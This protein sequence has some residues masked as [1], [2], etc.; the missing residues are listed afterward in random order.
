MYTIIIT[1]CVLLSSISHVSADFTSERKKVSI[2]CNYTL[3]TCVDKLQKKEPSNDAEWCSLLGASK[4]NFTAYQ[5][6]AKIGLCTEEEFADL[7]NGACGKKDKPQQKSSDL[8]KNAF[9]AIKSANK[10]C[11]DTIVTC[12]FGSAIATIL[13]QEE[14][15][16][17]MF[18]VGEDCLGSDCK[19]SYDTIK[20]KACSV[21]QPKPFSEAV[22]NTKMPCFSAI[23]YCI[24]GNEQA[25]ALIDG[26]KYCD[27]MGVI[28]VCLP[29]QHCTDDEI[30]TLKTAAC[31]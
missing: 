20:T 25:T 28:S 10:H 13:S 9:S 15:Y 24:D 30:N 14:R 23:N 29:T 18:K 31:K 21:T 5:C 8:K 11:Q 22:L 16:C 12:I 2:A 6:V 1:V 26:E 17:N 4:D 27:A 19:D 7:K 3:E